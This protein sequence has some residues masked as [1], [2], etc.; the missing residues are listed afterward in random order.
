MDSRFTDWMAAL[1]IDL[2]Q[3]ALGN[4]S[5]TVLRF[6]CQTS[7]IGQDRATSVAVLQSIVCQVISLHMT[8]LQTPRRELF[9]QRFVDSKDNIQELAALLNDVL[10]VCEAK[11]IWLMIDRIGMLDEAFKAADDLFPLIDCLNWLA[12]CRDKAVKIIVTSRVGGRKWPLEA[13]KKG[14]LADQHLIVGASNSR[15]GRI[16][17]HT[18]EVLRNTT[19]NMPTNRIPSRRTSTVNVT[20]QDLLDSESDRSSAYLS[21]HKP[22][23]PC[24]RA[25]SSTRSCNSSDRDSDSFP[26]RDDFASEASTNEAVS[27]VS[28]NEGCESA[29]SSDEELLQLQSSNQTDKKRTITF[30]DQIHGRRMGR[31]NRHASESNGTLKQDRVSPPQGQSPTSPDSHTRSVNELEVPKLSLNGCS[32]NPM[33]NG[34]VSRNADESDDSVDSTQEFFAARSGNQ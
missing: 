18:A 28:E 12:M 3:Q 9:T 10:D 19:Q 1:V 29:D 7:S 23:H 30:A 24:V 20:S 15:G 22:P 6:F 11:R 13:A 5:N 31:N 16:R 17:A 21:D 34:H 25:A 2:V 26:R 8:K 33:S 14:R 4:T 32:K 27:G